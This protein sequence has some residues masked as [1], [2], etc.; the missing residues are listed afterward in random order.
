MKQSDYQLERGANKIMTTQSHVLMKFFNHDV[1][2]ELSKVTVEVDS[3]AKS[4]DALEVEAGDKRE[5]LTQLLK[6]KTSVANIIQ[7]ASETNDNSKINP[8]DKQ[9][10]A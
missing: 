6:I 8:T 3:L 10:H 9:P 7:R 4:I 5:L 2:S 1:L